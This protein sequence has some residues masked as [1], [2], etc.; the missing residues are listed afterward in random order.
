M[1]KPIFK[2][3]KI[4]LKKRKKYTHKVSKIYSHFYSSEKNENVSIIRNHKLNIKLHKNSC[5]TISLTK[6]GIGFQNYL[7]YSFFW[8][9]YQLRKTTQ[10]L[11]ILNQVLAPLRGYL[12]MF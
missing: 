9:K 5:K 12:L 1:Y 8:K 10:M 4:V 2:I 7:V 3:C 11:I 6:L